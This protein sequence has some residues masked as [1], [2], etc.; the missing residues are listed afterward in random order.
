MVIPYTGR[1]ALTEQLSPGDEKKASPAAPHCQPAGRCT[2]YR[3]CRFANCLAP[4]PGTL[5]SAR[6]G[7]EALANHIDDGMARRRGHLA[8]CDARG[9]LCP[10]V[11]L[12]HTVLREQ[13]GVRQ[14]W[15]QLHTV[16]TTPSVGGQAQNRLLA[17]SF[18]KYASEPSPCKH[19][20]YCECT[21]ATAGRPRREENSRRSERLCAPNNPFS[22]R[23]ARMDGV[24][25]HQGNQ[26][27]TRNFI[28]S[29]W[30][31]SSSR[32]SATTQ[33]GLARQL[34]T[35]SCPT[36]RLSAFYAES[37]HSALERGTPSQA[38]TCIDHR[39]ALHPVILQV[40]VGGLFLVSPVLPWSSTLDRTRP[41][42]IGCPLPG[43]SNSALHGNDLLRSGRIFEAAQ[44]LI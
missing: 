35:S 34:C 17:V 2:R 16:L 4:L 36:T 27:Y 19:I 31:H 5:N 44:T 14:S 13:V 41:L 28:S 9:A 23:G 29:R 6:E 43:E 32:T 7:R 39:C 30:S 1:R 22:R 18:G 26:I 42:L 11:N 3:G 15:K 38:H 21:G 40:F 33:S 24:Q 12:L 10:E 25:T 20:L 8:D 37:I